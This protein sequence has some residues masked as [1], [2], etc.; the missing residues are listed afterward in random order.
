MKKL[1]RYSLGDKNF[2]AVQNQG[3]TMWI[4]ISPELNEGKVSDYLV[5]FY[6][7][8]KEDIYQV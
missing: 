2:I 5:K 6:Q 3:K 4:W 7:L 8:V 1:W